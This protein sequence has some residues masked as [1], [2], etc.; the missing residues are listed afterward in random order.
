MPLAYI[1][2]NFMGKGKV[3]HIVTFS[4]FIQVIRDLS[5]AKLHVNLFTFNLIT[6]GQKELLLIQLLR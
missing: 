2:F 1:L 5:L 4:E 6:E 3:N